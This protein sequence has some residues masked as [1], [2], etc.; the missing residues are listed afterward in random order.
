M[1]D[2]MEVCLFVKL[3]VLSG[4]WDLQWGLSCY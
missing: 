1:Y 2:M 3:F 4:Q